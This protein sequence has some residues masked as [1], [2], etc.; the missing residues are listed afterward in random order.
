MSRFFKK[1]FE[2][3]NNSKGTTLIEYVLIATLLSVALIGGY[4]SIGNRYQTLY[5]RVGQALP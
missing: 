2:R 4:R 1:I 5:N 3:I